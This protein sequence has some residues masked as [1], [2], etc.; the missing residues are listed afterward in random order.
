MMKKLK[1]GDK[2]IARFLGDRFQC[3]VIKVVDKNTYHLLQHEV[4]PYHLLN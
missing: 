4:L 3:E 2:V 1:L